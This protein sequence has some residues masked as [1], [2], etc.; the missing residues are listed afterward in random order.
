MSEENK[1]EK[2]SD[3]LFLI[4]ADYKETTMDE[5]KTMFGGQ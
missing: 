5:L 2:I 4:P 1:K 3:D